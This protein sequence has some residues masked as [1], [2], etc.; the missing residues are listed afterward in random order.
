MTFADAAKR[1]AVGYAQENFPSLYGPL[2]D[3]LSVFTIAVVDAADC[4]KVEFKLPT[5]DYF[6]GDATI[7]VDRE[8]TK[9]LHIEMK[10]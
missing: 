6:G 1:V 9:I 3:G 7:V 10:Q 8:A 4:W 2:W 5:D